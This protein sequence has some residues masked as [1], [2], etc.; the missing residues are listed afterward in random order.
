MH[1]RDCVSV[2]AVTICIGIYNIYYVY[3]LCSCMFRK[4]IGGNVFAIRGVND[5]FALMLSY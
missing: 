3:V 5:A 4:R 2:S 1:V